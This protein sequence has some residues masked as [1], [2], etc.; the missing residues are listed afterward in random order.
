VST[1]GDVHESAG[2]LAGSPANRHARAWLALAFSL[3]IHVTDEAATGFL[4]FYNP[5][6]TRIRT[7]I[8]WF[9]MPTFSFGIWL[10]GLVALV[11]TLI[12]L[13]PAVRRGV[14]GTRVASWALSVI[15]FFNGLG[16]LGGSAYFQRWLPGTTSAP[17]L[18]VASAWLALTT[19]R[20]AVNR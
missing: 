3:A 18:L 20:R 12:A 8:T 13:T 6:V 7:Q 5:L 19:S 14:F 16:H 9:P 4:E 2:L 17:L 11:F 15:M 1:V 10:T